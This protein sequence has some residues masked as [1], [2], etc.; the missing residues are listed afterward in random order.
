MCPQVLSLLPVLRQ[1]YGTQDGI[2]LNLK[3]KKGILKL[4]M[5]FSITGVLWVFWF[6]FLLVLIPLLLFSFLLSSSIFTT[7]LNELSLDRL[8]E[9]FFLEFCLYLALIPLI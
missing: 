6:G 8:R 7:E 2:K 4:L 5:L 3:K 1:L 9:L